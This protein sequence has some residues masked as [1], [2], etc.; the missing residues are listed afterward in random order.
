MQN[1]I[2]IYYV[3]IFLAAIFAWIAQKLGKKSNKGFKLNYFFW[4]L[5]MGVFVVLFGLRKCGVAVDDVSYKRIFENTA[6]NGFIGQFLE[7]TMEPGYLLLNYI[8]SLFTD[9]FQV[10]IFI[11]TLIP[12]FLYYKALEYESDKISMFWGVF[13]LGTILEYITS[14]IMEKLFH[15]RWW[16]YGDH[17]FHI[18]GRVSLTTS[19][20]FGALGLILVYF[21]NPFFLKII[22]NIPTIIFNIIM[23]I[24]F[25]IFIVDIVTSYVIISNLK[26]EGYSNIKDITEKANEEVKKVLRNKSIFNRRL[27]NAFPHLK[28]IIKDKKN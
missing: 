10:M 28:F 4:I 14:Y 15:A 5:S 16:D 1:S 9:N 7:T 11:V 18:N 19:L 17:R 27:L 13:L 24:V 20:G 26:K 3:A 2:M 25:V 22:K 6:A 8:V 23:I 21:F 12:V